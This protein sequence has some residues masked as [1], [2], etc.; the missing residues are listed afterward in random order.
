MKEEQR[1]NCKH[2]SSCQ[3]YEGSTPKSG[4]TDDQTKIVFEKFK[5]A[6]VRAKEKFF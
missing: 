3:I 6:N 2:I 4:I 1:Y 5:T